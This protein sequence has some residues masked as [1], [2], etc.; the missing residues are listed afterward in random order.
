MKRQTLICYRTACDAAAHPCGYNRIT[1]GLYCLACAALIT[2]TEE[3]GTNL[4]PL[5]EHATVDISGGSL[6]PG[7]IVVRQPETK[8]L[9]FKPREPTTEEI[10]ANSADG[11]TSWWM[12]TDKR[13]ELLPVRFLIGED[14]Q[15]ALMSASSPLLL[16]TS[17]FVSFAPIDVNLQPTAWPLD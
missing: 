6:L 9:V 4:F 15:I 11:K 7:I 8:R 17:V 5:L 1:H 13:L 12:G 14:D 10:R 16:T 2:R 3:P